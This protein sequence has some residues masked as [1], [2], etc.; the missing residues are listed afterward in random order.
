VRVSH[1]RVV[2]VY[3]WRS[4]RTS[5]VGPNQRERGRAVGK[6][7]WCGTRP[8]AKRSD[9]VDAWR[10][11]RNEWV[12]KHWRIRFSSLFSHAENKNH[13]QHLHEIHFNSPKEWNERSSLWNIKSGETGP[14]GHEPPGPSRDHPMLLWYWALSS[15]GHRR[16]HY[17]LSFC[18]ETSFSTTH[19]RHRKREGRYSFTP[20][21]FIVWGRVGYLLASE[22][23]HT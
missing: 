4:L 20:G 7:S 19:H 5:V 10:P 16:H 13:F 22:Q 9:V 12:R 11:D 18:Y 14:S 2:F 6:R 17:L 8:L 21:H 23:W 3:H 1:Y 15:L